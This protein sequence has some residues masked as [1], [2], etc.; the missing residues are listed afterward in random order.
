[1]FSRLS[2]NILTQ[3][4]LSWGFPQACST[5]RQPAAATL[6]AL[7]AGA[8]G[9]PPPHA[10][11]W[12]EWFFVFIFSVVFVSD[13][14]ARVYLT[15]EKAL[16]LAFGKEG[17]IE[18][19]TLFLTEEQASAIEQAA[20]SRLGTRVVTYY[21]GIQEKKPIGYAFFMTDTVRTMPATIMVVVNPD[22]TVRFV[23]ILA[24]YEPEDYKPHL[25]WLKLWGDKKLEEDLAIRR[26]IPNLSGATLTART[27][28]DAVRRSLAIFQ[29]AILKENRS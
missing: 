20:K 7:L 14:E 1:M 25:R 28:Q 15:Q 27:I 16:E 21:V 2:L 26:D 3:R 9:G 29:I 6:Q 17:G 13:V 24:F 4:V 12:V 23:E 8:P 11:R 5:V 22:A 10:T 19:K 18:R